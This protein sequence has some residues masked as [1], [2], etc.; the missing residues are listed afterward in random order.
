MLKVV[1][2]DPGL[3]EYGGHHP[4]MINAIASTESVKKG[5]LTLEVY[6]NKACLNE[7]ISETETSKITITKHFTTD[8]YQYF[9]QSPCQVTLN[10]YI[11]LLSKEYLGVFERCTIS[12]GSSNKQNNT[13]TLFLYHTLNG[14]H[15]LALSAAIAIYNQRYTT[16]L[17]HCVFLMYD[18]I[19]HNENGL[20]NIQHFLNFKLGFSSLLKHKNVDFYAA[21]QE[22]QERYQYLL[23]ENKHEQQLDIHPCGLLSRENTQK[24]NTAK[25]SN[26]II[27]FTGDAKVN[28]GFLQ[29]PSL[30]EQLIKNV[31]EKNVSFIIQYTITNN[32]LALKQT[33]E[34]LQQLA[35]LDKRIELTTHFW[36]NE[37]LHQNFAQASYILFNYDSKIYKNQ[38]SGVLWLAA[39]YQLKMLFLTDNW[40]TR[41]AKKLGCHYITCNEDY[42]SQQL[43]ENRVINAN[44]FDKVAADNYRKLLF[45]DIG[46]WLIQRV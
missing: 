23:H 19:K 11:N 12:T 43:N 7:F 9:Y 26:A 1:I 29:L 21:E 45:Q 38:S 4:A 33:D 44:N 42:L 16:P 10:K 28:K 36:S 31:K 3:R 25:K 39:K 15:A 32:G 35:K 20:F 46:E 27:L 13:K 37:K 40:L 8:F 22:L 2:A 18:P 24:S 14:E 30:V 5:D 41:E 34:H 6:C 17:Q